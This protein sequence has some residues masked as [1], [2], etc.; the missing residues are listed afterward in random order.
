MATRNLASVDFDK[1]TDVKVREGLNKRVERITEAYHPNGISTDHTDRDN[2]MRNS[3]N[4]EGEYLFPGGM[5]N[6]YV[7]RTWERVTYFDDKGEITDQYVGDPQENLNF[8][9]LKEIREIEQEMQR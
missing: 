7:Y 6:E 4:K 8:K 9:W 2:N 5:G 3:S 1:K